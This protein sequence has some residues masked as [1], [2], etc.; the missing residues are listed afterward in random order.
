[1]N[2]DLVDEWWDRYGD[3]SKKNKINE[4]IQAINDNMNNFS[5]YYTKTDLQTSGQASVHW[6]N[7]TNTPTYFPAAISTLT[8]DQDLDMGTYNVKAAAFYLGTYYLNS[9]VANNKVPDSDKVDGY[10]AT[11]FRF[12]HYTGGADVYRYPGDLR[13]DQDNNK[14]QVYD[15]SSW[16][17]IVGG[18]VGSVNQASKLSASGYILD[19]LIADNKVPDSDKWDGVHRDDLNITIGGHVT[20]GGNLIV[21]GYAKINGN[22]IV[23]SGG[24][25]RIT[26]GATTTI[27]AT[28]KATGD[29]IFGSNNLKDDA[30]VI[31]LVVGGNTRINPN[32]GTILHF[33]S[34]FDGIYRE[35]NRSLGTKTYPGT[36]SASFDISPTYAFPNDYLAVLANVREKTHDWFGDAVFQTYESDAI[37]N[38]TIQV[39]WYCDYSGSLGT[40]MCL[41]VIH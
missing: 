17:N 23:D 4:M 32:G 1:M 40:N 36:Y 37:D 9:L 24:T 6:D 7:I 21:T 22:D 16:I 41:L 27:S 20:T 26:L 34:A 29:V 3:K 38:N 2:I 8:I 19:T 39:R 25:T 15:G 31:R 28:L 14:I 13:A 12:R 18:G 5:N 33:G 35:H 11:N 10:H 30:E